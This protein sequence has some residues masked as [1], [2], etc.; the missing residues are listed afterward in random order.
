MRGVKPL[1]GV[2]ARLRG[3]FSV[4]LKVI[5]ANELADLLLALDYDRQRGR[6]HPAHRGQEKP[7][8][9]GVEGG[10]GARAVDA[11]QPVGLGAAARGV[12]QGL[13]LGIGAQMG[14]AVADG[15]R[16]HRLQ[17]QAADGLAQRLGAT[18]VLLDETENQLALTP[19]VAGVNQLRHVFALGQFDHGVQARF[20][21]VHRL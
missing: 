5:A 4:D 11:H 9:A 14:K 10:H 16:R 12:G 18:C 3:K 6:L 1:G 7:P 21:F 15:L 8:I 17:P 20:G 19:G 13:H 2:S